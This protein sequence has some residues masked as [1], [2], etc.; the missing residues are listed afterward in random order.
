VLVRIK[1]VVAD[2]QNLE[3]RIRCPHKRTGHI[4]AALE[5]VQAQRTDGTLPISSG[6]VYRNFEGS[7]GANCAELSLGRAVEVGDLNGGRQ[8]ICPAWWGKA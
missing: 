7:F 8:L 4:M 6:Y 3:L 1:R 2:V 5:L